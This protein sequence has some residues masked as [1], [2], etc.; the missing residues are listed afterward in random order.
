LTLLT[1]DVWADLRVVQLAARGLP[2]VAGGMLDQTA[3][4]VEAIELFGEI[5]G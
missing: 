2:P 1:A 4:V 5:D 3:Q